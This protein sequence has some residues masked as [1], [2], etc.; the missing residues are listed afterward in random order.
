MVEIRQAPLT[1]DIFW[2]LSY[3]KLLKAVVD[4]LPGAF[5]S[6]DWSNLYAALDALAE[7]EKET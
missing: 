4:A 5:E 7:W 1:P 2:L 3:C 6:E